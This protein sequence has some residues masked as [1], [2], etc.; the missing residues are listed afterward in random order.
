MSGLLTRIRHRRAETPAT[1][2]EPEPAASPDAP[3]PPGAATPPNEPFERPGFRARGQLRRRLRYLR[4]VRE[5]GLRDLGGLVYDLD[6]FGRSRDDLVRQKLEALVAIDSELTIVGAALGEDSSFD[7]LREVGITP[8]P[9]CG[10]LL[11]SEARFCS[12][13][14][15]RVDRG[16][17]TVATAFAPG[18]VRGDDVASSG[19]GT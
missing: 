19:A 8:C 15:V 16:E 9:G 7:E 1:T 12:A 10:A 3:P 5:L 14:G 18:A 17:A 11:P 6:R 2:A 13:C 4:R